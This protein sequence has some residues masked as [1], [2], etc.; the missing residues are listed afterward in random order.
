MLTGQSWLL[1]TLGETIKLGI[2][3]HLEETEG[4]R[5]LALHGTGESRAWGAV[6]LIGSLHSVPERVDS[7]PRHPHAGCVPVNSSSAI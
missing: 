2:L 5:G 3:I 4:I 7:F 6:E 1:L